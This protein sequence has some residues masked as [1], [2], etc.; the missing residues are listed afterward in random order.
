MGLVKLLVIA[1]L[2]LW[3]AA[4]LSVAW[5]LTH[6]VRRTY[7]SAVSRKRPGDPSE[8]QPPRPFEHWVFRSRNLDFPV[9]DIKGDL[10]EGGPVIILS[11]GWSDSRVGGL[12]RVEALAPFASRLILWDSRGHGEAPGTCALGTTE[13]DDLLCLLERVPVNVQRVLYGWSL[14]AGISMAAAA[15]GAVVAAVI[16]ESPY[17]LPITPARNVLRARGLPYR[18]NL[19]PAIGLLRVLIGRDLSPRQFDRASLAAQLSCPL[20]VLHGEVDEV[21]PVEDGQAIARAAA[22]GS[23]APVPAGRHND[24]WTDPSLARQC[25]QEVHNFLTRIIAAPSGAT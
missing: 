23:F 12:M 18:S 9:W 4:V 8:L 20:L 3:I 1:A 25:H 6:P 21:C 13:V 11:H 22:R 5:M 7:A 14:G 16:A 15:R 19:P 17:R 24:L 2:L 10:A